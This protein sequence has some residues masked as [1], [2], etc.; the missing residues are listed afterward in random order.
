[1]LHL[2][3]SRMRSIGWA[4]FGVNFRP[5]HE[6]EAK[7]EGGRIFDTGPSFARLQYVNMGLLYCKLFALPEL[8]A[9]KKFHIYVHVDRHWT[10]VTL[11]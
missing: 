5:L 7:M 9:S 4:L 6:T 3:T 10:Q 2:K 8:Q 1:M 11:S